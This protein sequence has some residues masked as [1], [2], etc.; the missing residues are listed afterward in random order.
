VRADAGVDERVLPGWQQFSKVSAPVHLLS[1]PARVVDAFDTCG[2]DPGR[3]PWRALCH[4]GDEVEDGLSEIETVFAM[5][6][7]TATGVTSMTTPGADI[8]FAGGKTGK[9]I[10]RLVL[11]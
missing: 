3:G 2:W 7:T 5:P 9:T 11:V 10:V 1:S 6:H 4:H 8:D